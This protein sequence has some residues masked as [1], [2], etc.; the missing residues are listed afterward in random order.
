MS[1]LREPVVLF[2]GVCHLCHGAVRFIVRR[3]AHEVFRFASLQSDIGQ[4]LAARHGVG[5]LAH[6]VNT[7]VLLEDGQAYFKSSAILRIARRLRFPWWLAYWL[8]RLLPRP[9]RDALY[10]WVA[11]HRYRWFGKSEECLLPT[12]ALRARL[13]TSLPSN[14]SAR[15]S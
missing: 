9:V 6:R 11:Q 8:G 13:L 14:D 10:D 7:V 12:A 2:D 5:D 15:T 4:T 1:I 3:D